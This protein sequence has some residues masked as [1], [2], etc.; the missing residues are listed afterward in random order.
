MAL[1]SGRL[2]EEQ[3]YDFDASD[4]CTTPKEVRLEAYKLLNLLADFVLV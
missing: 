2:S 1:L 4:Q 3:S